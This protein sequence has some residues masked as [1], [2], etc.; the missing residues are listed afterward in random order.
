MWAPAC[1]TYA[2][3]SVDAILSEPPGVVWLG[4]R[5]GGLFAYDTLAKQFAELTHEGWSQV[6][7]LAWEGETLWLSVGSDEAE[8]E[9]ALAAVP[10]PNS[11]FTVSDDDWE[12]YPTPHAIEDLDVD[13]GGHV[14]VSDPTSGLSCL[15]P[16][17][18]SWSEWNL[19]PSVRSILTRSPTDLWLGA[20]SVF[21]L[22]HGG[23]C[24]P[25]TD[26]VTE[27]FFEQN[28]RS[29][30]RDVEIDGDGVW[31]ATD[32]G[33]DYLDTGG[34]PFDSGDDRWAHFDEREISG[35]MGLQG[36]VVGADGIKYFWGDQRVFAFDDQ[37]SPWDRTDDSWVAHDT[38]LPLWVSG[39]LD[40]QGR[41]L[42]VA[43]TGLE[44]GGTPRIVVFDP[45]GTPRDSLDDVVSTI[46]SGLPGMGRNM[47][48]DTAG[49]V[50]LG[51]EA[52]G[53]SGNLFHWDRRGTPLDGSDD[54]WTP[55]LPQEGRVWKVEA[56][57]TGG[58]WGTVG[59]PDGGVFQFFDGGTLT[60]LSD[61]YFHIYSELGSAMEIGPEGNGW[62]RMPGGAGILD[63]GGTP[64]DPSDDVARV[65]LS[66]DR[67]RFVSDLYTNG[68]IDED[69]RFWVVDEVV[70]V[71]EFID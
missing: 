41:L 50:W 56:D 70:Q 55:V 8:L 21:H 65:L 22:D 4:S 29:P 24:S 42:V 26:S 39:D 60:D 7:E 30:A 14:W 1:F 34:T 62:F 58:V 15:E 32:R 63:V 46:D 19:Q 71:F 31:L 67:L 25:Q 43:R 68:T 69:G 13:A 37:G 40:P 6:Y 64:R 61:D 16:L 54:V 3:T 51:T 20:E 35:L 48:I 57:P 53:A 45:G 2:F 23:S 27:L 59:G 49:Q 52:E 11:V 10:V 36:V 18:A 28:L 38:E 44:E 9:P 33:V 66:P 5:A 47:A 12:F 17:S